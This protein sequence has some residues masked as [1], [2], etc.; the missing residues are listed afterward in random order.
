VN[1]VKAAIVEIRR[2]LDEL[3]QS[4]PATALLVARLLVDLDAIRAT[5]ARH[6]DLL[7]VNVLEEGGEAFEPGDVDEPPF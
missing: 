5:L 7:A 6:A 3:E 1:A 2:H 4:K